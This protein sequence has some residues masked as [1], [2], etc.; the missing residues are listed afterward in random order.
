MAAVD[1]RAGGDA[2]GKARFAEDRDHLAKGHDKDGKLD[3]GDESVLL[4]MNTP[5]P[6]LTKVQFEHILQEKYRVEPEVVEDA[7]AAKAVETQVIRPRGNYYNQSQV[8]PNR[9]VYEVA[10]PEGELAS[11]MKD[12]NELRAAQHVAQVPLIPSPAKEVGAAPTDEL[13]SAEARRQVQAKGG[14]K[15]AVEGPA[16]QRLSRPRPGRSPWPIS[17][18][19]PWGARGPGGHHPQGRWAVPARN[20]GDAPAHAPA[21]RPGRSGHAGRPARGRNGRCPGRHGPGDGS[22]FRQGGA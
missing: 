22:G 10:I 21:N 20:G 18:A 17:A 11:L 1:G 2:L 15:A 8:G 13:A 6:E 9:I 14:M 4:W 19:Q 3:G 7:S 16:Q 5:E 12:F